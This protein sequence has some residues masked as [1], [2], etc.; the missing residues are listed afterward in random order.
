MLLG[1]EVE[2][3]KLA[4]TLAEAQG[5]APDLAASLLARREHLARRVQAVTEQSRL[6]EERLRTESKSRRALALAVTV[7]VSRY[8]KVA[9]N[10]L[11]VQIWRF[12]VPPTFI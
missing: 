6:A 8:R 12:T 2:E 1:L 4:S 3:A 10:V 9:L 11:A 7:Q 5:L